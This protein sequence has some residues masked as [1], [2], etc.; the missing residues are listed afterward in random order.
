MKNPA[1]ALTF[2][3][4]VVEN[5]IPELALC[6]RAVL[7]DE[8]FVLWP[9]SIDKHHNYTGGLLVH[10]SEVVEIGLSM[11]AASCLKDVNRQILA[12]AAIWHDYGK[13]FDY[14]LGNKD[15]YVQIRNAYRNGQGWLM[16]NAGMV[17]S[18]V[19]HRY[20]VR[21]PTRS[22]AEWMEMSNAQK[23]DPETQEVIGHAILAHHGRIEWNSPIE[24]QTAEAYILH[25]ADVMS[26]SYT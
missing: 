8:R 24:P 5:L 19:P 17:W 14:G 18:K 9:G 25:F 15:R 11:A 1:D 2:L 13:I 3:N 22:Y 21:H 16:E 7:K 10:T 26:A 6:V 23:V 12:V 4:R 20:L